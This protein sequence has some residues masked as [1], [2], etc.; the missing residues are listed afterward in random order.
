ML[1]Y[2]WLTSYMR[3][4]VSTRCSNVSCISCSSDSALMSTDSSLGMARRWLSCWTRELR[5]RDC[6]PF[7]T[8]K[9]DIILKSE[10]RFSLSRTGD[11]LFEPDFRLDRKLEPARER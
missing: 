3:R 4:S 9:A 10:L 2:F 6:E 11:A 7:D 8:L 1:S 5:A